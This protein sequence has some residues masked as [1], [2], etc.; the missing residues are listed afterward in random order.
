M[1]SRVFFIVD[2]LDECQASDS[3][4][5][6]F[7]LELFNLRTQ[8]GA[9]IFA[10]SRFIPEIIDQFKTGISLEIRASTDDVV[11]YI[12]GHIAQLPFLVQQNPQLQEE[13]K[14]E[15]SE[16]VDGMYVFS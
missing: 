13:I 5:A 12:E 16:A 9:N 14:I 1:Y 8:H 3:C 4:R 7:L 2:A 10:T 15:I 11:K 6:R